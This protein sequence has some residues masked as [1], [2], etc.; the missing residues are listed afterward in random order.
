MSEP[1]KTDGVKPLLLNT[2]EVAILLSV[3]RTKVFELLA[4]GDLPAIWIGRCV[5]ISRDQLEEWIDDRLAASGL[6]RHSQADARR[7][8]DGR[9]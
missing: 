5:R 8:L 1:R 7:R 3:G 4:S 6:I 2:D 9:S